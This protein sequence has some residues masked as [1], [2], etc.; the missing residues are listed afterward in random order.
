MVESM[1]IGT[2][3]DFM[4]YS[5]HERP[6]PRRK[7]CSERRIML[8]DKA[9]VIRPI[10]RDTVVSELE[11]CDDSV[12]AEAGRQGRD[13]VDCCGLIILGMPLAQ[14]DMN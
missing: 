3:M 6:L 2:W 7:L 8:V 9:L 1:T 14:R 13:R 4:F 5:E 10:W 12:A 11:K